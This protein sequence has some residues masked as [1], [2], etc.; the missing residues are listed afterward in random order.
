[1]AL[2]KEKIIV[3]SILHGQFV[4][5]PN[6]TENFLFS[7]YC[8]EQDRVAYQAFYD[9]RTDASE[10]VIYSQRYLRLSL[11]IVLESLLEE[12]VSCLSTFFGDPCK[13]SSGS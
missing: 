13:I 9:H 2:R 7:E 4:P 11:I 10:I 1:M 5:G 6:D 12:A 8:D 3:I